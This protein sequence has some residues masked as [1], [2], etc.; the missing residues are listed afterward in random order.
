MPASYTSVRAAV[1]TSRFSTLQEQNLWR[2]FTNSWCVVLLDACA[3]LQCLATYAACFLTRLSCACC[4]LYTLLPAA[5]GCVQLRAGCLEVPFSTLPPE[6][7]LP[8]LPA[9][10][11]YRCASSACRCR[12]RQSLPYGAPALCIWFVDA[13]SLH[14]ST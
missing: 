4:R 3:R 14:V 10:L 8:T 11:T 6:G 2:W 5:S 9:Y 7:A 12:R 1:C 13:P